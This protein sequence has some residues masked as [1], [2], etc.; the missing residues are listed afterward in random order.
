MKKILFM[1]ALALLTVGFVSCKKDKDNNQQSA[2]TLDNVMEDGFYVAGDATGAS[3]ITKAYAF[4]AGINEVTKETREGMY[5]KYIVLE[6]GK[7]FYFVNKA[8]DNQENWGA[9]ISAQPVELTTDGTPVMGYKGNLKQNAKMK[10]AESGLYHIVLDFNKD[11]ALDLVGGPQVALAKVDWGV[12]GAMNGWSYVQG[13]ANGTTWTWEN[14]ELPAGGEFKFRYADAWK[15]QL[16]DAGL[17]KAEISIGAGDKIAAGNYS[18]E[19]GG[20]YKLT[21]TYT[22]ASGEPSNSFKS[23]IT[24]TGESQIKDYSNVEI[25]IVGDAVAEQEGAEV[26]TQWTWG[27]FISLGKP[28]KAGNVYTWRR[29]KVMLNAGE[30]KARSAGDDAAGV[31]AFDFG[32]GGDNFAVAAPG[33]YL[34]EATVN[35]ETDE[36]V[37]KITAQ[38]DVPE[39]QIITVKAKMPA[40]WT[41]TITAWVWPTGGDGHV[42]VPTKDGDWYVISEEC[43]ELNFIFR[44]GEDWDHGQTEDLKATVDGCYQIN[45]V[46]NAKATA[47]SI[48]CE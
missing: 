29:E 8:G 10:V 38:G 27:N 45:Y 6:A 1:S 34:V 41:N 13:S 39:K 33:E 47:T 25:H 15:I 5:E 46:E 9:E 3:E 12:S 11:G 21:L 35:A 31:V 23:E 4:G 28:T 19:E 18:V 2:T 40:E 26:D 37:L 42:V 43:Y 24:K 17:V 7:E 32:N 16:D 14:Q 44:N 36:K 30:M 20:V 48:D 22:L